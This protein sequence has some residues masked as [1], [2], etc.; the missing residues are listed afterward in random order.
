ML[1]DFVRSHH[2]ILPTSGALSGQVMTRLK[3]DGR[4]CVF[5]SHLHICHLTSACVIWHMWGELSTKPQRFQNHKC[6]RIFTLELKKNTKPGRFLKIDG[7]EISPKP[8]P[9]CALTLANISG[10]KELN[11]VLICIIVHINEVSAY[12]YAFLFCCLIKKR[13]GGGDHDR[14]SDGAEQ[15]YSGR[16][17]YDFRAIA[18]TTTIRGGGG[19]GVTGL[20]QQIQ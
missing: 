19:G 1:W 14:A 12:E 13:E 16:V 5:A 7:A 20:C 9:V 2:Q 10:E 11:C 15:K 3:L 8:P 6:H 4:N 18:V 17:N